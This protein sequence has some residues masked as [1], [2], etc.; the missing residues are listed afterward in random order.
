MKWLCNLIVTCK[1]VAYHR[2]ASRR[3]KQSCNKIFIYIR[4]QIQFARTLKVYIC[5]AYNL[6]CHLLHRC[7][8]RQIPVQAYK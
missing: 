5:S 6:Y 7:V 1:L 3:K 2:T 8:T 4:S